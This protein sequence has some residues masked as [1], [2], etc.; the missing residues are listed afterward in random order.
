MCKNY[1]GAHQTGLCRAMSHTFSLSSVQV[2]SRSD[3]TTE[4]PTPKFRWIPLHVMQMNKPFP[5][6]AEAHSGSVSNW[7][8]RKLNIPLEILPFHLYL[9]VRQANEKGECNV[10]LS[11]FGRH[12]PHTRCFRAVSSAPA[13]T[14]SCSTWCS[15]RKGKVSRFGNDEGM[16][17]KIREW[18]N[19]EASF[20]FGFTEIAE[21]RRVTSQKRAA[22]SCD[23]QEVGR[24][25]GTG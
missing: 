7:A 10:V 22:F 18:P 20:G 8:M 3:L 15:T 6:I 14:L 23:K 13:P 12:S 25:N 24:W 21:C 19:R 9:Y 11:Y 2:S 1:W 17:P 5:T 16:P 4:T